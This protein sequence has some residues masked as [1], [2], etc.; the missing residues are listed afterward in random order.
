MKVLHPRLLGW[1][2]GSEKK[3]QK[4]GSM[5]TVEE[6]MIAVKKCKTPA[7]K[8]DILYRWAEGIVDEC[9]MIA[10]MWISETPGFTSSYIETVKKQLK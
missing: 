10:A 9:S 3:L 4:T 1:V 2:E 5:Q 7:G 6:I 8:K